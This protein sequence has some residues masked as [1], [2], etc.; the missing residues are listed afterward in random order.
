MTRDEIVRELAAIEQ[1]LDHR[2]V[3][4]RVLVD[5]NGREVQRI[6]RTVLNHQ[7]ERKPR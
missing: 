3:I 4:T 7:E 1:L 6:S 5:P 2:I